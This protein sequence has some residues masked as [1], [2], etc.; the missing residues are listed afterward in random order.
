ME[1]KVKPGDLVFLNSGGPKMTVESLHKSTSGT[2]AVCSWFG[3]SDQVNKSSF[4]L[5]AITSVA[6]S[7]NPV[8]SVAHTEEG[9]ERWERK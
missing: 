9:F 5:A 4:P 7:D 8:V 1:D 3:E 6:I 2:F